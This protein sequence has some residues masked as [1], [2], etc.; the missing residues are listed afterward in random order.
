MIKLQSRQICFYC[1]CKLKQNTAS[2]DH[3][4]PIGRGGVNAKFNKV[5]S[6]S[7]CNSFKKNLLPK[8]YLSYCRSKNRWIGWYNK[9]L[10]YEDYQFLTLAANP[11]YSRKS[12][13]Q[14]LSGRV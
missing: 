9:G 5:I 6:C 10:S 8:E 4:Y 13:N 14:L 12:W 2:I 1:Q 7:M 11:M 3:Y